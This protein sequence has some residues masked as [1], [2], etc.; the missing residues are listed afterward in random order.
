MDQ[1][2]RNKILVHLD[3]IN[4]YVST[5]STT[6]PVLVELD[7]TNVCNHDCPGCTGFR[8]EGG[9]DSY[10]TTEDAIDILGQLN[11]IGV[12]AVTFTG[13]G[14]PT[15][16]KDYAWI[17]SQAKKIGLECGLITNGMSI[18]VK[19]IPD[20]VS[21]C[22]WIRVS[23]DASTS[24]LHEKIHWNGD[25]KMKMPSP[26][27]FWKVVNN[28]KILAEY[29]K[30]HN[31]EAT[32]GC[33]FLVGSH[34]KHEILPFAKLASESGIDYCQYRPFHYTS[35]DKDTENLMKKARDKYQNNR[36]SV[37]FSEFKFN[38]MKDG[39]INRDYDVCHGGYFNAHI[40]ANYYVYVCCHLLNQKFACLGNLKNQTF[41][42]LWKNKSTVINGIDVH[43]C[44]PLCRNDS[45]NRILETII[46][47][48]HM[49]HKNFL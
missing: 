1:F 27:N 18:A 19:D 6:S 34:T 30:N 14:D 15:M 17:I 2:S 4:E 11:K 35:Y 43:K 25:L 44:L 3:V 39:L 10:I 41:Q 12:K 42:Q 48:E 37:L 28:T 38:T 40:A 21:S 29:K 26:Q 8:Q 24:G 49:Q 13:G 32:I 22:T 9:L 7:L 46:S 36:F 33:A 16:H 5:G 47:A 45:A 23:W 20:L 31:L